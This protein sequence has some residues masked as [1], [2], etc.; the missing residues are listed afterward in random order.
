MAVVEAM[1]GE[2]R[3][4]LPE[5]DEIPRHDDVGPLEGLLRNVISVSCLNE[6]VS[7]AFLE[8]ARRVVTASTLRRVLTEILTDEV[9]HSRLGWQ[10][11]SSLAPRIDARMRR[12]LGQYL[13]PAFAQLFERHRAAAGARFR[14]HVLTVLPLCRDC[15]GARH[16]IDV[17]VAKPEDLAPAEHGEDREGDDAPDVLRHPRL[18]LTGLLPGEEARLALVSF[19]D[20]DAVDRPVDLLPAILGRAKDSLEQ[21]ERHL[22]ATRRLGRDVREQVLDLRPPDSLDRKVGERDETA[23]GVL[24]GADRLRPWSDAPRGTDREP[25]EPGVRNLA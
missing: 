10:M 14:L 7:V 18:E 5:L 4:P 9:A 11:L 15:D 1:G 13:I 6:T 2:A 23:K 25:L 22:G 3:A 16:E 8:S 20:P 24:C 12:G 21:R 17:A 19:R